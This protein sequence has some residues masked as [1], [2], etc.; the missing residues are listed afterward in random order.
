M[1]E[2]SSQNSHPA[3]LAESL[4]EL[5][6]RLRLSSLPPSGRLV[7]PTYPQRLA[8][9]GRLLVHAGARAQDERFI[10]LS[11]VLET[12][13]DWVAEEPA[14]CPRRLDRSFE[15]LVEFLE[16]L[17]VEIDAGGTVATA[18]SDQR[19]EV[20]RAEFGGQGSSR[21]VIADLA[22]IMD[23]WE[24]SP[25]R[26]GPDAAAEALHRSWT[27][28]RRRG[29]ALFQEP[30]LPVAAS[31]DSVL[32]VQG[33]AAIFGL[34]LDSPFQRDEILGKIQGAG[35]RALVLNGPAE[36]AKMIETQTETLVLLGDNLEPSR[37][38]ERVLSLLPSVWPGEP[39]RCVLVCGSL[40]GR[41]DP[42]RRAEALGAVGAWA[43]PHQLEDLRRVL[44][45]A[46]S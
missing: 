24:A 30:I 28:L 17:L 13:N 44:V 46:A 5:V 1:T 37:N 16:S 21:S 41:I 34:L 43:P 42:Q 19:W 45:G 15:I 22:R 6:T 36:A 12:F 29:D 25:G 11:Q 9:A 2:T 39:R 18:G 27:L 35:S 4:T 20:V 10:P 23:R 14:R 40:A 38:L 3:R 31:H 33:R 32:S 26:Q 8:I 7:L